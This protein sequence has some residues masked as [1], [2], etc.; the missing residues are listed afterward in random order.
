MGVMKVEILKENKGK[1][2]IYRFVNIVNGKS[3]VGSSVNLS[4]RLGKYYNIYGSAFIKKW[5]YA[6]L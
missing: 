2:G 3:Y 4:I 1:A 6:Y 5:Y